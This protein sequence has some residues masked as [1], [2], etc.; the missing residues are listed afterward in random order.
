MIFYLVKLHNYLKMSDCIRIERANSEIALPSFHPSVISAE[1]KISDSFTVY[2]DS[3]GSDV[4]GN[5]YIYYYTIHIE[6]AEFYYNYAKTPFDIKQIIDIDRTGQ[7]NLGN[8]RII[9]DGLSK[10]KEGN[11]EIESKNY[12]VC[13][14]KENKGDFEGIIETLSKNEIKILLSSKEKTGV[15]TRSQSKIIEESVYSVISYKFIIENLR[16]AI[17]KILKSIDLLADKISN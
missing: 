3:R 6:N 5:E 9:F 16:D 14:I 10:I 4:D 13:P 12:F 7:L 17:V 11:Q 2:V 1:G 15:T 8:L